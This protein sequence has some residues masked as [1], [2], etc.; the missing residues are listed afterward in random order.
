MSLRLKMPVPVL[1]PRLSVCVPE[2]MTI[3]L[4]TL[5]VASVSEESDLQLQN[6]IA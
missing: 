1:P 5:V 3:P 2:P 4:M 6:W